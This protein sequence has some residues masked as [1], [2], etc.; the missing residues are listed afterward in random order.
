VPAY[1]GFAY[2]LAPGEAGD[3]FD[4]LPKWARET[5]FEVE[6]NAPGNPTKDQMR[7]MM[8]SLLA[9]RFKLAVH[10]EI[11]EAPVLA[12]E[13]VEPARPGPK[14]IPHAQGPP[15]PDEYVEIKV[16]ALPP[17][18]RKEVFPQNCGEAPM[19]GMPDGTNYVGHRNT[20]METAAQDIYNYG[21][22]AGEVDTPVID[23]TGLN[24]RYDYR[25]EYR[26]DPSH[27]IFNPEPTSDP[28]G[29]PFLDALRK[30]LGL[31]LVKTKGPVRTIVIDHIEM[32]A[33]N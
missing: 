6:A 3:A 9:D 14:L 31:K 25:L 13:L 17:D 30:Q 2:K 19:R 33:E 27:R 5:S 10:F 8:Q 26:L 12:L 11:R 4:H 28:T 15:C 22:L 7:L 29:T 23:R 24:G 32:P 20:T 16:G 21:K 1:I 18:P